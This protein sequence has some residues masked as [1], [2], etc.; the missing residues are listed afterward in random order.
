MG[1]PAKD[2]SV[3]GSSSGA[4][5][6][7]DSR[8]VARA[9]NRNSDA[10]RAKKT[11][12][13]AQMTAEHVEQP[14]LYSLNP[15]VPDANVQQKKEDLC[16]KLCVALVAAALEV[17]RSEGLADQVDLQSLSATIKGNTPQLSACLF[18]TKN[19]ALVIGKANA[20][21][22]GRNLVRL[23]ARAD[24]GG[25]FSLNIYLEDL[26]KVL[27]C[28]KDIKKS[29]EDCA[30]GVRA[31][32]LEPHSLKPAL[33]FFVSLP[34]LNCLESF[35][36]VFDNH[37]HLTSGTSEEAYPLEA[38]KRATVCLETVCGLWETFFVVCKQCYPRQTTSMSMLA[39][40]GDANMS[41][42]KKLRMV[43]GFRERVQ[44]SALLLEP[45]RNAVSQIAGSE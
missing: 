4:R 6:P 8:P 44:P 3:N 12:R 43:K 39:E 18:A 32:E 28:A 19:W 14:A 24:F 25:Q 15:S 34:A 33:E 35:V 23:V 22:F 27:K 31:Q 38:R 41:F 30:E 7:K 17:A 2:S 9:K 45:V 37:L 29:L 42:K 1:H 16:E 36:N 13:K 11:I 20:R 26:G 5:S 40:F 21:K 10:K